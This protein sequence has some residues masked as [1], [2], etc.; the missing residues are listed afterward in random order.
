MRSFPLAGAALLGLGLAAHALG[1]PAEA[2]DT[3]APALFP[4]PLPSAYPVALTAGHNG[5]LSWQ[6]SQPS[7]AQLP[8]VTPSPAE[9]SPSDLPPA[10]ADAPSWTPP[11]G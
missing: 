4:I 8:P 5:D 2:Q 1:R 6:T 11:A 9:P 3:A 10:T 7:P